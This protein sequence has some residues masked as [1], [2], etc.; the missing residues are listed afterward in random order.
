VSCGLG[1]LFRLGR[2]CVPGFQVKVPDCF[3]DRQFANEMGALYQHNVEV[4]DAAN[5]AP[6][7]SAGAGDQRIVEFV[8]V[9]QLGERHW[10]RVLFC[11]VLVRKP[12]MNLS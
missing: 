11:R 1:G 3:V 2:K 10:W 4:V 7:Q 5:L 6:I 8:S 12:S 9:S